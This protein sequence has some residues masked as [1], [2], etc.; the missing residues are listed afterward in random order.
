[1]NIRNY[2][3]SLLVKIRSAGR[4][5][6]AVREVHD[7]TEGTVRSIVGCESAEDGLKGILVCHVAGFVHMKLGRSDG[8]G[9]LQSKG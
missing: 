1:L 9:N 7:L 3:C 2:D 6:K 8:V 5:S 4:E